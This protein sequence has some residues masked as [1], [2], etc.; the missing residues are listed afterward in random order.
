MEISQRETL[1]HF[2]QLELSGALFDSPTGME[3]L[4]R[5]P[6]MHSDLDLETMLTQWG[7]MIIGLYGT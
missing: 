7:N 1:A 4:I 5:V 6:G 2:E 3:P